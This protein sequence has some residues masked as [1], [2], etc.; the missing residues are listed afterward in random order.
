MSDETSEKLDHT[1][2]AYAR[3]ER[4]SAEKGREIESLRQQLARVVDEYRDIVAWARTTFDL[5]GRPDYGDGIDRLLERHR[6]E[7]LS[8]SRPHDQRGK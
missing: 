4:R 2:Q 1:L 5:A 6:L 8:P 7:P 3:L